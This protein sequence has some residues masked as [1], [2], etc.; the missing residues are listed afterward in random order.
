M[1]SHK[2]FSLIILFTISFTCFSSAQ[3]PDSL[4]TPYWDLV[5]LNNSG[6]YQEGLQKSKNLLAQEPNFSHT[7]GQLSL[8]FEKTEQVEQGLAYFDS[9]R[10]KDANN[11]Y[12][13]YAIALLEKS[14][15]NH[16]LAARNFK[17][18]IKLN[19]EYD[20]AYFQLT[21]VY[22]SQKDLDAA[23]DFFQ[24]KIKE[25]SLNAA[26]YYGLG[27][28]YRFKT[29][30][31]KG[32]EAFSKCLNL[33]PELIQAY[34]LQGQM[35]E[36]Q[37]DY[38]LA[39]QAWEK[40]KSVASRLNDVELE[41]LITG[42]AGSAYYT[43]GERKK[44]VSYGQ[45]ALKLARSIADIK[46]QIKH[47]SNLSTAFTAVGEMEKAL[48]GIEEGLSIARKFNDKYYEEI[49]F[50]N[51]SALA[52]H[53][54]D[55]KTAFEY[56][57]K[58]LKMGETR[59]DSHAVALHTWKLGN[60]YWF[61]ANFQE[62]LKNYRR[63][64]RIM[65]MEGDQRSMSYLLGT[66]GTI[67]RNMGQISTAIDTFQH[68][69][70]LAKAINAKPQEFY[71]LGSLGYAYAGWSDY[72][73]AFRYFNQAL[74]IAESL[75]DMPN[76]AVYIGNIGL[77]YMMWG[78][79]SKSLS[80]LQRALQHD[81]K[82]NNL[83]GVLRH[84]N[85]I[86]HIYE[87]QGNY[88]TALDTQK[89]ALGLAD[90]LGLKH[91][92]TAL[93][94]N[95]GIV[96]QKVGEY[97]KAL[98]YF[99]KTLELSKESQERELNASILLNIGTVYEV[100]GR[101]SLALE[102]YTES[103]HVAEKVGDVKER[104]AALTAIGNIYANRKNLSLALDNYNQ[105]LAISKKIGQ[106]DQQGRLYYNL[107]Q[108]YFEQGDLQATRS[109]YQKAL[110]IANE[111]ETFELFYESLAGLAAIAEHEQNGDLAKSYYD[112]AIDRIESVRTRLKI[113]PYKTTFM[114][115]K[116]PIYEGVISLLLRQGQFEQAYA[117]LQ[118]FRA[119]SF[120]E[121][122]APERIDIAEGI[123]PARFEQYRLY[124]QKLRETY[125]RL[126]KEYKKTEQQRNQGLVAALED[127]LQKIRQGHQNVLDEIRLH[128]P[129]YAELTGVKQPLR[130]A[131]IQK[132]ALQPGVSL[133]EYFVSPKLAA[134][135]VIDSE[136]SH[137]EILGVNGEE[138]RTMVEHLRQPFREIKEGKIT[139]LAEVRFD[140]ELSQQLYESIFRPL[141]KYLVRNAQVI[142]VP[143]GIL[144]YL[145]Y[146][147]LVT[148]IEKKRPEPRVLFSRYQN[149]HFLIEKY[150]ISYT[151]AA[152]ILALERPGVQ[153][154][155]HPKGELL[156]FG[157]P[158]FGVFK[159]VGAEVASKDYFPTEMTLKMSPHLM[160]A[161]LS[162]QDVN[163]VSQ[164][165]KPAN[166]FIDDEATEDR[167]KQ[168]AKHYRNVYLS[169][170]AIVDEDQPMY[171][172]VAFAQ[173]D[174]SDEDGFLHTYEVF[175][176]PLSADLVTL[177]ACETGLGKL[178]RGE[179]FIG[180]TRAFLYAGARSVLVSMW[181]V[182]EST[183]LLMQH[184]YKN[185]KNGKPKTEALRQAKLTLL[186]TSEHGMSFSHPF[187]WAPFVLVG[188]PF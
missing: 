31:A 90:S 166:I 125:E 86:A 42:A 40:G 8:I 63:A 140:L 133:V 119:R 112:Q 46:Q 104:A 128:H 173:D 162:D 111:M 92:S 15:G 18:C 145:P 95:I 4:K 5:K 50:G 93:L 20:A 180:L 151:P 184:F 118:R 73:N 38:K 53:R 61:K 58:A 152:T 39:L 181:S 1:G 71:L 115:D 168:E 54:G 9:L 80:Y 10:Q 76:T 153:P 14:R 36:K 2:I 117:Y 154:L 44:A 11:A 132:E 122:L 183:A 143:D 169:T 167:F 27:C 100:K 150:A 51:M 127:S 7:Y 13:Y 28:V 77:V 103:L 57:T 56:A 142:I 55:A 12:V 149:A 107:G 159:Q 16:E 99:A 177:S 68:A 3:I 91:L 84:L 47:L 83:R 32:A 19:P 110:Q 163:A 102:K 62:A 165:M 146:E 23:E 37:W 130:L 52:L 106:K 29:E 134:A 48:K 72:S 126:G 25:D 97:D 179:G 136:G 109:F 33:N 30:W 60:A 138:L 108:V 49:L 129:R 161:P 116:I 21:A 34:H 185:L 89:K 148:K 121:I 35:H 114:E 176:Q 155:K 170:H 160:L 175:N 41:G 171:S 65:R 81:Q 85:N 101:D 182:D 113:E 172:L 135:W 178:S 75:G 139:N 69:L 22:N 64:N 43:L 188:Q 141:E 24:S 59:G 88:V 124:E 74:S 144:H 87:M 66:I 96:H 26:A 82:L 70:Q 186:K 187:L 98:N 105:A 131:E 164:I 17:K 157:K 123:S 158:D 94:Q 6:Q 79:Y 137:C 147:A 67:Y 120:L 78:N 45:E 174:D 156:A